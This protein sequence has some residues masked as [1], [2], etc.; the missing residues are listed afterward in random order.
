MPDYPAG[1]LL[2]DAIKKRDL[3]AVQTYIDQKR[4]LE[5]RDTGSHTPLMLAVQ[6]DFT[7]AVRALIEGG[8]DVHATHPRTGETAFLLAAEREKLDIMRMLLDAGVDIEQKNSSGETALFAAA[9]WDEKETVKW[10]LRNGADVNAQRADGATTLLMIV[11]EQADSYEDISI[12]LLEAGADPHIPNN[13]GKTAI[14]MAN[15]LGKT[16]LAEQMAKI[17]KRKEKEQ[18]EEQGQARRN[19]WA[20]LR[21]YRRPGK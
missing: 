3:T 8:A 12:A 9:Y 5:T 16:E 17:V 19:K 6:Q 14:D 10:L 20:Q 11:D 18:R 13:D 21:R 7:S 1:N 15:E 4:P 2:M